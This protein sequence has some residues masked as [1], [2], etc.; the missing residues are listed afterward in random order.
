MFLQRRSSWTQTSPSW[1]M[2]HVSEGKR[3]EPHVPSGCWGTALHRAPAGTQQS[4][5][6]TARVKMLRNQKFTFY[7]GLL[8]TYFF[9]VLDCMHCWCLQSMYFNS[10]MSLRHRCGWK[11]FICALMVST[12]LYNWCFPLYGS[13]EVVSLSSHTAGTAPLLLRAGFRLPWHETQIYE[14]NHG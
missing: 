1:F 9:L 5:A 3:P 8:N 11:G 12:G 4:C 6:E 13:A 7:I 2:P 10:R 14:E